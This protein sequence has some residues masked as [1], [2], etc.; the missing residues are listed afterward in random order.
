MLL[1]PPIFNR[2]PPDISVLWVGFD[3]PSGPR[4]SASR[5]VRP[6]PRRQWSHF[7]PPH[8]CSYHNKQLCFCGGL[9]VGVL[10]CIVVLTSVQRPQEGAYFCLLYFDFPYSASFFVRFVFMIQPNSFLFFNFPPW[11]FA[12]C[13]MHFSLPHTPCLR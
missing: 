6:R 5:C 1:H 10:W 12:T 7:P 2:P 4:D 3:Y 13:T 8:S 11:H 9:F